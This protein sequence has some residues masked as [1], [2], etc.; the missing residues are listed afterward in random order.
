[1][2]RQSIN[3][4]GPQ[5]DDLSSAVR[6]LALLARDEDLGSGDLT[7]RLL[8]HEREARFEML[9]KQPGVLAGQA[10]A[11]EIL[12]VYDESIRIEWADGA[13]DG[14][15]WHWEKG[16]DPVGDAAGS[17]GLGGTE[18]GRSLRGLTP[19]PAVRLATIVGPNHTILA[20]ERVLLNFL[21]RLCGVATLTRAYVDAVA[22]TGAKI[23]DTRKTT[24]GW[25]LLEKYA[26][27]CGGGHNHRMGLYDAVLIKDNH[28]AGIEP[29]RLAYHVFQ[30]L[31][32]AAAFDPPPKFVEVE[33]DTLEQVE[34]LFKVL[35]INAILLDNFSLEDLR[36]AVALRDALGLNGRMELEASGGINLHTVRA[37]A[38][39]GVD[40][41][42]VGAITHSATAIDLSLQRGQ[43]P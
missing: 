37:V 29:N 43:E 31:S 35:G 20:A 3:G 42:S 15:T 10:I 9:L 19:F 41:I 25:R 39:T 36:E 21:Q 2:I 6:K 18:S 13:V 28:L 32:Q 5:S 8:E 22:G 1:M 38:E 26:V 12:R 7:S 27:R 30:M 24:P 17:T 33:A 23:Y 11:P 16:S 34:Q 40:R 14:A 4:Y